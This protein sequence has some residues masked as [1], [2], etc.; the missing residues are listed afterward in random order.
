[1]TIVHIV[2][3]ARLPAAQFANPVTP[4]PVGTHPSPQLATKEA[5]DAKDGSVSA[6]TW[7]ATPGVFA[8]AVED[9]E[10]S[11]FIA[12]HATFV[13]ADGQRFE[14]RA[15]DAAYFPPHTR[16]VWTIHETVRKTYCIW[17]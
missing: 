16:G 1:M 2:A 8:R 13:T 10:F 7:E 17:K 5:Y 11:H 3:P 9:A 14:F 15:G 4:P 6:G 12:G